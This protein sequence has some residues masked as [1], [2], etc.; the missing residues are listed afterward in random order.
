MG[1][2][3]CLWDSKA[4][5]MQYDMPINNIIKYHMGDKLNEVE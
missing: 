1:D 3:L 5:N 4:F 2:V